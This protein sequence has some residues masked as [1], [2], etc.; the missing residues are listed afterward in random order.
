[1]LE[2]PVEAGQHSKA[3]D[4]LGLFLVPA[5]AAIQM[6]ALP[7]VLAIPHHSRGARKADRLNRSRQTPPP[8]EKQIEKQAQAIVGATSHYFARAL[9][10]RR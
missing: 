9:F 6:S 10:I 4:F 8:I 2:L 5:G 1:M 7:Q 3:A